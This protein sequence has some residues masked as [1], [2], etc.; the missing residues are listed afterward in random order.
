MSAAWTTSA[1]EAREARKS[2]S[3]SS[4]LSSTSPTASAPHALVVGA[5]SK[6]GPGF[7]LCSSAAASIGTGA[8]AA[9][10]SQ[11][12]G[13]RFDAALGETRTVFV[14]GQVVCVVG[15]GKTSTAEAAR[16][17]AAAAVSSLRSLTKDAKKAEG[18]FRVAL[19][20]LA[21]DAKATAEGSILAA[22]KYTDNI[23]EKKQQITPIVYA[24][25]AG[26]ETVN[27]W[28]EGVI[29]AEA[30]N[31][32]RHLMETPANFL[33]PILFAQRAQSLLSP[34]PSVSVTVRDESWI[35]SQ[36]MGS[37]LSVARGSAEPP[38]FLE[39]KYQG[40]KSSSDFPIG[41][42]GK[43]VTFDTGGISIKPSNDMALMK[44]D[45]G[46]AAVVVGAI[47]AIAKLGLPINV[48]ACIPLTE[49]MPSG[50]ATKPGD[51]VFAM[52]G[53]SIE[54]VDTDAEGRL[55]LADAIN[56]TCKTFKP[57]SL[58][59]FSTL[60]G[61]IDVALGYPYAGVFTTSDS[62]WEGLNSAG[63]SAG[64]KLW[65]M[66]MDM[67]AYK[68]QIKSDAAD[69]KNYGGRSA[70]SCTAAVFLQEFVEEGVE[71]AHIDIAGVM[72]QSG[73][74]GILP[75]GMTGRPVRA[76]VEYVKTEADSKSL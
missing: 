22:F 2:D 38:R 9:I 7:E 62:L 39:I 53:K 1:N 55:I 11:L 46:G 8:L 17:A 29:L 4:L 76:I 42:V 37:F 58:I 75:K 43:G 33:T 73:S 3:L 16:K 61:A 52:N 30:Q 25:G 67:D 13:L 72:K 23:T 34:L 45:M 60:T 28:H 49:N 19:Q 74:Y 12:S 10:E 69:L 70:G 40:N 54:V 31:T 24:P 6:P 36:K 21:S 20:P 68:S 50:T 44:G 14:D 63:K 66:P 48:V 26:I 47:E 57:K 18:P 71:F 41:L 32:A 15:L 56:Y 51:V 64:D 65:R 59:E 27:K 35:A 5:T